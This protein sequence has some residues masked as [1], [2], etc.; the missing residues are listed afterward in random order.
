MNVLKATGKEIINLPATVLNREGKRVAISISAAALKEE[1]RE[2]V[3]W[4][5]TL[6]DLSTI[7]ELDKEL[8][9]KYTLDDIVSKDPIIQEI[10]NILPD[11]AEYCRE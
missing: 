4:V 5:E 10:F 1:R 6:R 11:I 2:V 8:L 9:K 3:G 7:E